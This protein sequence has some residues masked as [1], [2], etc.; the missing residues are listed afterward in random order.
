MIILEHDMN[1]PIA[2]KKHPRFIPYRIR[3]NGYWG[4]NVYDLRLVYRSDENP[5]D[6]ARY[7][8]F[9]LVRDKQ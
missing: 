3:R 6:S 7:I 9:R 4:N 1:N 8:G 5:F 2:D